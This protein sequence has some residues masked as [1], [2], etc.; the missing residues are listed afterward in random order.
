MARSPRTYELKVTAT[1]IMILSSDTDADGWPVI[2]FEIERSKKTLETARVHLADLRR[3][4]EYL[5]S[6]S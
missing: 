5:N 6:P 3:A 1:K 2:V 4:Q